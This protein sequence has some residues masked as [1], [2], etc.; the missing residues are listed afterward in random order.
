MAEEQIGTGRDCHDVCQRPSRDDPGRQGGPECHAPS[1]GCRP[2]RDL[3]EISIGV[4]GL[5]G[6][7]GIVE[8]PSRCDTGRDFHGVVHD[9]CN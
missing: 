3:T 6:E 5:G 2:P 8:G 4:H 1:G 7:V 9:G